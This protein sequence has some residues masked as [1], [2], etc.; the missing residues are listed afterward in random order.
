MM[1]IRIKKNI[2]KTIGFYLEKLPANRVERILLY[3]FLFIVFSVS[4]AGSTL[5]VIGLNR[6]LGSWSTANTNLFDVL[7]NSPE[8]WNEEK[9]NSSNL[10]MPI[11][12]IKNK[13]YT[14]MDFAKITFSD[15]EL[16]NVEFYNCDFTGAVFSFAK[17]K[18]VKFINSRMNDT[19]WTFVYLK[20]VVFVNNRM[21]RSNFNSAN[22]ENVE[23]DRVSLHQTRS[24]QAVFKHVVIKNSDLTSFDLQ[25][26]EVDTFRIIN[27]DLNDNHWRIGSDN[28]LSIYIENSIF[29]KGSGLE[30]YCITSNTNT[31]DWNNKFYKKM[32]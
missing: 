8:K 29:C 26:P 18:N 23:F 25:L 5:F 21:Q 22:L 12:T 32:K 9:Q 10:L 6:G 1:N 28:H 4:I 27:S 17:I 19:W 24:N 14:E 2:E 3:I 13:K 31:K 30:V 7:I 16:E 15:V 11:S 20:N